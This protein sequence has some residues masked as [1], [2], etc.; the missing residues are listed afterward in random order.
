MIHRILRH[1]S[2]FM[3]LFTLP[4]IGY[5]Q[6]GNCT[7][8]FDEG[9]THID[10][11]SNASSVNPGDTICLLP[12]T[13]PFLW[14]SYLHGSKNNP[15]V[16]LNFGGLVT[17]TG[18][19]YG[20]KIDSC[21]HIKFSGKG[22][23]TFTYG[24]KITDVNGAG[25]SVEGLSTDIEIEGI[26]VGNTELTGIFAKT[27]PSCQ[28]NSTRDKYVLRNLSIHDCYFHHTGMEGMYIGNS[29]FTG[30][31]LHC[32][33]TD[34]LVYPHLLKGVRIYN[35]YVEHTSWDGIQ[36][37]SSDSGCYIFNNTVLYDSEGSVTNQ[38]SGILNGGGSI[39]DCFSN[40]IKDGKG[41]GIDIFGQGGQKFYNNLIVN[42]GQSNLN[43]KHGI[44]VGHVSTISGSSFQL[45]NNTIVTPKTSG[46]KFNNLPSRNNLISNNIIIQ[47]NANYVVITN[48]SISISIENNLF[49]QDINAAAFMNYTLGNF[50]LQ[51]TS[52]AVNTG[53]DIPGFQLD[54][55]ILNRSRPFATYNDRG[56]F[57]C[58]DSSL[59]SI[60]DEKNI[61]V[62]LKSLY[63]NPGE[64]HLF[65]RFVLQK[66][67]KIVISIYNLQ[68][69]L[70]CQQ[71]Y[72]ALNPGYHEL[73]IGTSSL[74]SGLYHCIIRTNN[75]QVSKKIIITRQQGF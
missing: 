30:Y 38:M 8:M 13:R 62:S 68:G 27:D 44:Y 69:D 73:K 6:D 26:E 74:S 11:R 64:D 20:V 39:C 4:I 75:Q 5:S 1:I 63:P 58:H 14:L 25:M 35:N 37:S 17:V 29:F 49:D 60:G 41:D 40:V 47:S 36:V 2:L 51:P 23:S 42:A 66:T 59:Y 28:F 34:T 10:G 46:V 48:P 15:I 7:V 71:Q 55:D 24:I 72:D 31:T 32:N 22:E 21:S 53:S 12:G 57:E 43:E 52:P 18:H 19:Y 45:F 9:T 50:D 61:Q 3:I 16:I 33:G 54:T 67:E 65:I 70:K 56:A